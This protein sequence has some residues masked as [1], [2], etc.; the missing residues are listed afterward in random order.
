MKIN[1]RLI[2]EVEKVV[3]SFYKDKRFFKKISKTTII[4]LLSSKKENQLLSKKLNEVVNKT[5]KQFTR[6]ELTAI[7]RLY[8]R[9]AYMGDKIS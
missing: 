8:T 1:K 5:T 3:W 6:R 2:N 9:H 7:I 4:R